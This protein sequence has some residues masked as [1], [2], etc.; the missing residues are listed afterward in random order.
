MGSSMQIAHNISNGQQ[1]KDRTHQ[2]LLAAFR[3]LLLLAVVAMKAQPH[4]P[5]IT[6]ICQTI[7]NNGTASRLTGIMQQGSGC[8]AFLR[9][10]YHLMPVPH[11]PHL[12]P[13]LP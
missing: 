13:K 5:S 11:S 7:Q 10:Y 9:P 4:R 3:Q 8:P 12:G 1:H 2:R 6:A